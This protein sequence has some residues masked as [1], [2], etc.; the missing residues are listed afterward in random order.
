MT[1][2]FVGVNFQLQGL[3]PS[4]HVQSQGITTKTLTSGAMTKTLKDKG[5]QGLCF[6]VLLAHSTNFQHTSLLK[7]S[8]K[9]KLHQLTAYN[10]CI[11]AACRWKCSSWKQPLLLWTSLCATAME[12]RSDPEPLSHSYTY[13]KITEIIRFPIVIPVPAEFLPRCTHQPQHR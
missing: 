7:P 13:L 3:L 12:Q 4:V 6:N 1:G 5:F 8:L 9:L 11:A 2:M 10:C